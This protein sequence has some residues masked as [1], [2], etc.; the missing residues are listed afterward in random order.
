MTQRELRLMKDSWWAG[1]AS[2]LQ[3]AADKHDMRS[4]YHNLK[5]VF[6]GPNEAGTTPVL[7]K[8]GTTLLT[9]QSDIMNRWVEHF[10]TVL[11]QPSSFDASV[12]LGI[13]Q[14]PT[15]T[16]LAV[17]PSLHEV[18]C[19]IKSLTN[20]KTPGADCIPPEV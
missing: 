1:V 12:L 16:S 6:G 10:N 9:R 2:E 18:H 3:A 17:P 19:A 13:P 20:G 11:N 14:R 8:D 15:D 4:F 5:T 7:S